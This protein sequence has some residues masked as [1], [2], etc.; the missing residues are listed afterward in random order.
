MRR[1]VGTMNPTSSASRSS[2]LSFSFALPLP[3]LPPFFPFPPPFLPFPPGFTLLPFA[4][5]KTTVILPLPCPLRAPFPPPRPVTTKGAA[6][7]SSDQGQKGETHLDPPLSV[8]DHDH[9]V[10]QSFFW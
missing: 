5:F 3:P 4:G 10:A 9:Y 1:L 2:A 6:V 8:L 7:I